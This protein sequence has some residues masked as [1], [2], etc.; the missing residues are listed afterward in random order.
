MT[1]GKNHNNDAE[2]EKYIDDNCPSHKCD[3]SLELIYMVI[4]YG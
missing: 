3:I 2:T 4:E 1:D